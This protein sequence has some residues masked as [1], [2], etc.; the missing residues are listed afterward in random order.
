LLGRK[1]PRLAS[2]LSFEVP[3][4][5]GDSSKAEKVLGWKPEVDF[6]KLVEMMYNSDLEYLMEEKK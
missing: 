6:K 4:L 5:L 1:K 3:V 2:V